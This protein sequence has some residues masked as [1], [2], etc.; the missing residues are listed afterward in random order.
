[1]T[2]RGG[3]GV[4]ADFL[5]SGERTPNGRTM[6]LTTVMKENI[7][8]DKLPIRPTSPRVS[9]DSSA[10]DFGASYLKYVSP[11]QVAL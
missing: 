10:A 4:K 3:R 6:E 1:M 2:P 7:T 5:L 11:T 8:S 9:E